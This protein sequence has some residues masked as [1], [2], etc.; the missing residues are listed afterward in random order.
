MEGNFWEEQQSN[1]FIAVKNVKNNI[2]A[3][4][5]HLKVILSRAFFVLYIKIKKQYNLEQ[6]HTDT[7]TLIS[8]GASFGNSSYA[9]TIFLNC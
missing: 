9:A 7:L 6:P 8:V 4:L 3:L 5:K 2:N 1:V